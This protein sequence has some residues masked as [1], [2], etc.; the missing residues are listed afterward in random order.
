ML[1]FVPVAAQVDVLPFASGWFLCRISCS[2]KSE[3]SS[4]ISRKLSGFEVLRVLG[5]GG[6]CVVVVPCHP[7]PLI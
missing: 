2:V 7:P 5:A 6:V 3:V 1:L 4:L